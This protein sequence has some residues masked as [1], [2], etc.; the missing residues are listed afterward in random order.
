MLV[1]DYKNYVGFLNIK[2][3]IELII[4]TIKHLLNINITNKD[5]DFIFI[6]NEKEF[7][8]NLFKNNI[9]IQEKQYSFFSR[10]RH[11]FAS[12]KNRDL[13]HRLINKMNYER[14]D[15]NQYSYESNLIDTIS[16][17]NKI[18]LKI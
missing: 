1:Y 11:F 15:N 8:I 7:V 2:D 6:K 10:F 18:I 14:F 4:D 9:Q 5:I 12:I 16:K 13:P 3:F 17:I